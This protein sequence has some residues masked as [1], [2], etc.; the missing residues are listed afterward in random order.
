MQV[1]YTSLGEVILPGRGIAIEEMP[2]DRYIKGSAENDK[3]GKSEWWFEKRIS[4]Y[5]GV[6]KGD[7]KALDPLME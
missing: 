5:E 2:C 6:A 7:G 4:W 1:Y 3:G